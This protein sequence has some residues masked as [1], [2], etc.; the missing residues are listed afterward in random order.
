M[1]EPF[2][3]IYGSSDWCPTPGNDGSCYLLDD[4]ILI[5]TGWRGVTHLIDDEID[6]LQAPT[7]LFTHLHPDHRLAL[8]QLIMYWR[9]KKYTLAGLTVA[10]PAERIQTLYD[11]AFDY[12]FHDVADWRTEVAEQAR[13]LPLAPGDVFE[14]PEH[15]VEVADACHGTPARMYRITHRMSGHTIGFTGDTTYFDGLGDF[16]RGV[17]ALVCECTLADIPKEK[18]AHGTTNHM[19]LWEVA[20]VAR[21]AQPQQLI[22]THTTKNRARA[23]E[24]IRPLV[25]CDVFWAEPGDMVLY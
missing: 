7:M 20:D 18:A 24:L 21:K 2:L 1:A 10:G 14:T 23:L 13:V 16:F 4:R 19:N 25:D 5:D 9:I 15:R 6:P 12:V 17:D 22:L 8:P 11:H 3:R